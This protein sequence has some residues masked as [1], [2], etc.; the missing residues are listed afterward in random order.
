MRHRAP[1]PDATTKSESEIDEEA[2]ER[3]EQESPAP[4]PHR[5]FEPTHDA[6]DSPEQPSDEG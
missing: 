4:E 1:D 5:G 6:E 2:E 3:W